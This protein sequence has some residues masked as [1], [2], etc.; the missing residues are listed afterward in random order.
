MA[1]IWI[2]ICDAQSDSKAKEL[3]NT[4]FNI[5]SHIAIIRGTNMNPGIL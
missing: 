5:G 4:C 3:I 2:D 1:V